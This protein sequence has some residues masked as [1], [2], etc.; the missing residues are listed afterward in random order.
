[1]R[2]RFGVLSAVCTVGALFFLIAVIIQIIRVKTYQPGG[3][4]LL[5]G[6]L[7]GAASIKYLVINGR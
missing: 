2:S 6:G 4:F 3:I 1:M 7:T 5:A